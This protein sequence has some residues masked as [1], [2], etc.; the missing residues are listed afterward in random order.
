MA[1]DEERY[2]LRE[3]GL[4]TSVI[5]VAPIAL[6]SVL[7]VLMVLDSSGLAIVLEV[8]GFLIAVPALLLWSL[9]RNSVTVHTRTGVIVR[10][11]FPQSERIDANQ[12]LRVDVKR[13]A[14]LTYVFVRRA[15]GAKTFD[16]LCDSKVIVWRSRPSG[17]KRPRLLKPTETMQPASRR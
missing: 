5:G 16:V 7:F 2:W 1:S 14:P 12:R 6:V 17:S 4:R 10:R 13:D 8:V 9:G 3:W 15:D 11:R